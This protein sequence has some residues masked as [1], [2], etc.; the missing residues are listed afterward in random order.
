[1]IDLARQAPKGTPVSLND[2]S[3]RSGI[4]K[5]YLEQLV[6]LLKNAGLVKS[7]PGRRGGYVLARKPSEIDVADVVA[8]ASGPIRFVECEDSAAFCMNVEFCEC[9]PIWILASRAVKKVL[10]SHTLAD[11]ADPEHMRA[12]RR[13][14]QALEGGVESQPGTGGP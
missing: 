5:R 3:A 9:R 2:V 6:V 14:V 13:Q 12:L 8:A 4:S 11:L 10:R 1:M 7:M